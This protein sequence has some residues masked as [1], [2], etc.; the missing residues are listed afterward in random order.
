MAGVNAEDTGEVFDFFVLQVADKAFFP[1]CRVYRAVAI[2]LI[3]G[4]QCVVDPFE[5]V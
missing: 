1:L 5:R 3:G 4:V 2:G